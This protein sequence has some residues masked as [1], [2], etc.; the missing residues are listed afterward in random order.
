M[1]RN[2]VRLWCLQIPLPKVAPIIVAA[3]PIPNDLDVEALLVLLDQVL[4]GLLARKVKVTSYAADGTEVE[5]KLQRL[6]KSKGIAKVY[7]IQNP[8][9]GYT[10]KITFAVFHGQ[11]IAFVQDSS[12]GLKTGH[13]SLFSGARLLTFGN[14]VALYHRIRQGAFEDGSPLYHRDVEKL[15]RQDDNAATRLH[16]AAWVKFMVTRHTDWIFEI[17]YT[18]VCGDMND[19]WQ[20]RSM[21]HSERIKLVLRAAY[22]FDMWATY[23]DRCGYKQTQYYVSREFA[24]IAN[25]LIDGLISLIIIYCD[26]V[27]GVYPLLPW[28]HSTEPCEHVFG[29]ARHQ[30]KDFTML[31]FYYMYP[32][33]GIKLREAVLRGQSSDPKARAN[34]YCHKYFNTCGLDLLA[35]AT[36]PSDDKIRCMADEAEQ[37]A[38][39]LVKLLGVNPV[40]LLRPIS[41]SSQTMLPSISAWYDNPARNADKNADADTE[42]I[43]ESIYGDNSDEDNDANEL[44]TLVQGEEDSLESRT[45][46]QDDQLLALTCA[47]LAVTAE[48]MIK[49]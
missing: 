1:P 10:R 3:L 12:H 42:D 38:E 23:L 35:L 26:Y 18:T 27:D 37:E 48:D 17:I 33:L 22:F 11:P 28:L 31:D 16:S 43:D 40:Q 21:L 47:S 25:I 30:V 7:T 6:L 24:D 39:S 45:N 8:R 14:H 49:V 36:F 5:R 4:D 41:S 32:K 20:S 34:G 46:K 2:K 19:A 15:D 9:T 29:E 13:N 44:Q